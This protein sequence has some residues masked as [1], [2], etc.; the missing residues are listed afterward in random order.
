MMP[1]SRSRRPRLRFV[2]PIALFGA[3]AALSID[4]ARADTCFADGA[5]NT[6]VAPP[7][8]ALAAAERAF[9]A[10]RTEEAAVGFR[11]LALLE[12]STE[13]TARAAL[14]YVEAT[15]RIATSS[16]RRRDPCFD[17]LSSDLPRLIELHCRSANT[18]RDPSTCETLERVR[19][20]LGRVGAEKKV[21]LADKSS[22]PE[23]KRLY[24]EA[25]ETYL[26]AFR[27]HCTTAT[28][29]SPGVHCDELAYNAARAFYAAG[30]SARAIEAHKS[31]VVFDDVHGMHSPLARRS[32]HELG[33]LH[34][35][36]TLYESAAQFFELYASRAPAERE[37]PTALSDAIVMRLALGDVEQGTKDLEAF[38]KL[39]AASQPVLTAEVVFVFAA[40]AQEHGDT[41]RALSILKGKE[42]IFERAPL[43]VRIREA[44]LRARAH[45]ET[46]ET[47][48]LAKTEYAQVVS[49][50]GTGAEVLKSLQ[51][52]YPKA[53]E[54]ERLRRLGKSLDAV[55]EA[56]FRAAEDERVTYVET[57]KPLT[58]A[59]PNDGAAILRY[60]KRTV[61]A[62]AQKRRAAIERA[63]ATYRRITELTPVPPPRWTVDATARVAGMWASFSS[64]YFLVV[65][66]TRD[67]PKGADV[68]ST[69][70]LELAGARA[71]RF[72]H[73]KPAYQQCLRISVRYQYSD[74][75]TKGCE[76]WLVGRKLLSPVDELVPRL[77]AGAPPVT[78]APLTEGAREATRP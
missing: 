76:R 74:E 23:A 37:A 35:D 1:F 63:E 46:P 7:T 64:D 36:L 25:A 62:W 15:T 44:A 27:D 71:V 33:A 13:L 6:P 67:A 77:R 12:P 10:S 66:K 18:T 49:M 20:D 14:R 28:K 26:L 58:Y 69:D 21:S 32:L 68:S 22:G 73:A 65:P 59:G 9:A 51:H 72:E 78:F 39:F 52:E 43:D 57:V 41:V 24:R 5:P 48:V 29:I 54:N 38:L 2:G 50:W 4:E 17:R 61:P 70:L 8:E 42:A 31:L 45:A 75:L 56:L 40:H 53:D 30:L 11:A 55:G 60:V 34:R 3:F 47:A 16:E 19:V